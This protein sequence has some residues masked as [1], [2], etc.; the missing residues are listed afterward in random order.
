MNL[1]RHQT[2]V[3][4]SCRSADIDDLGNVGEVHIV[5]APDEHNALSAVGVDVREL[6]SKFALGYVGLIDLIGR[7]P[8]GL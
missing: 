5:V 3:I 4:H 1:R 6:G 7:G 8:P 2:D